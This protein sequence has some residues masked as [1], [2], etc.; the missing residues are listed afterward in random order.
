VNLNRVAAVIL[1][2]GFS[3]RF[4]ADDK[5]L[6]DL[7]GQPLAAYSAALVSALPFHSATAIVPARNTRLMQ[8][9]KG[10][11]I[12]PVE[13]HNADLGQGA[14]LA[15][16]IT[17]IKDSSV[18]AALILLADMPFVTSGHI[19]QLASRMDDHDAV[20]S[21]HD[22]VPQPPLLFAGSTFEALAMLSGDKG[23]KAF[24]ATL[25]NKTF[26]DMPSR[27]ATDID[28]PEA[29]AQAQTVLE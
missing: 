26:V 28:T 11:G 29:L 3:Q 24:L 6:S 2:S 5:L 20:A 7:N 4:G 10:A 23:G 15:L 8:L 21:T 27:E 22:D 12:E 19:R 14:S 17:H 18:D 13:N 25:R 16:A 9:Y 1:A